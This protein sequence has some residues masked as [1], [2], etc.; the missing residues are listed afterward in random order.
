LAVGG[1]QENPPPDD[2]SIVMPHNSR[3]LTPANCKLQ[4]A[5]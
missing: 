3:S 2:P 1:W 5:N 4:T